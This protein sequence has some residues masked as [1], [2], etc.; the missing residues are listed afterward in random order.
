MFNI[1]T[2]QWRDHISVLI[3][4]SDGKS[5]CKLQI[6]DNEPNLAYI[7]DLFVDPNQRSKGI[8]SEM[9]KY[10]EEYAKNK[11]CLKISLISDIDNWTRKW[12]K[13]IGYNEVSSQ[14]LFE[15]KID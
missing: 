7:S 6:Y 8:G 5:C 1:H 11:G 15:K 9:I 4:T 10:C 2:Y 3:M 12:Y 14:V 13:K